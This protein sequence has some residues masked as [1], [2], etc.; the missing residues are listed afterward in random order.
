MKLHKCIPWRG[1][2]EASTHLEDAYVI[3]DEYYLK[4]E[5]E[6]IE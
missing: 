6:V 4:H 1:C 3:E 2:G 5:I